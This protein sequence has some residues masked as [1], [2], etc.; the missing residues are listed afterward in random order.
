MT[1]A[2]RKEQIYGFW[3]SVAELVR[4]ALRAI[5]ASK[6]RS[7]LTVLGIIIGV[8]S[9]VAVVSIMQGVFAAF[10]AEF[11]SLGADTMFVRPNYEMSRSRVDAVKRLKMT[12]ADALAIKD[13]APLVKEVA[14]F[15]MRGDT[16]AYRSQRDTTQIIGTT[17]PYAPINNLDLESGRFIGP[18]DVATRR[19]VC[20]VGQDILD[21]LAMPPQCLGEEIQI[22]RGTYTIVGLLE[23]KG[24]SFGQSQDDQIFIPLT[25]ATQQYGQ[26]IANT[27]FILIQIL[28]PKQ[29]DNAVEQISTVLRRTHGIRFGQQDDFRIFTV[30]A[31]KR[32]I[33]QFTGISTMVVTAIVC[34]TLVVGG[35]GIMNIMLVSV[36]ERTREIGIRM[37]VGAKR[38]HILYQF[39][40][41]SVTLSTL[42]GIVGLFLGVGLSHFVVFV[43]RKTVS[44]TFPPAY[45]PF[46]IVLLSLGFAA[47][48]GAVFGV[49]PAVKASRLD[50]IDAL[51]Y[52]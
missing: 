14:P 45:V 33:D 6:M 35:I 27:V 37:A 42:G 16:I 8:L 22:G 19:K 4:I 34:I 1:A 15:V 48:T 30:E 47:L 44:E 7:F 3:G 28:D 38:V 9:V 41:E 26:D 10:F 51:R 25:A 36:T 17:E 29:T 24:G 23:K 49:Y 39:L 11:N 40:I 43:L 12:Y 32:V 2:I 46:W 20:V 21:K 18:M 52:E 5:L 50:P 13:G 31:I